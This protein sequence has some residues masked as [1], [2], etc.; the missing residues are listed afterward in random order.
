MNNSRLPNGNLLFSY[1]GDRTLNGGFAYSDADMNDGY[2]YATG[3]TISGGISVG[4]YATV[5]GT[6]A[7]Y[8]TVKSGTA[9]SNAVTTI[10]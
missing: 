6:L 3:G 9:S 7:G 5:G 2:V 4:D 10:K 1:V 8:T